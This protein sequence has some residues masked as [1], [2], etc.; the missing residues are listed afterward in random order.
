MGLS[1]NDNKMNEE[2]VKINRTPE[3]ISIEFNMETGEEVPER[4]VKKLWREFFGKT[5]LP[6]KPIKVFTLERR[7]YVRL[8]NQYNALHPEEAGWRDFSDFLEYG[9]Q[10]NLLNSRSCGVCFN[11][12]SEYT[13]FIDRQSP[14]SFRSILKH[15]LAHIKN[16]DWEKDEA[17]WDAMQ[18]AA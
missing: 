6:A 4:E 15:E 7:E 14:D 12:D 1:R 9:G 17:A 11:F 18:K 13:I 8:V 10:Q 16:K 3:T 5:P 2:I